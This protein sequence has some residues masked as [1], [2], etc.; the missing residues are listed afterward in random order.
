MSTGWRARIEP[1]V[2]A[3][4]RR[5]AAA[6]G[7][8][9]P[10]ESTRVFDEGLLDSLGY[11]SLVESIERSLDI[12]IDGLEVDPEALRTVGDLIDQLSG[13]VMED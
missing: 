3:E 2:L 9:H 10:T 12:E 11:V 4:L 13:A 7:R 6:S 5:R 8:P 1:L